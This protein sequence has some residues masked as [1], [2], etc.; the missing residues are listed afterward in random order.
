MKGRILARQVILDQ[1]GQIP[2]EILV[3][4][5]LPEGEIEPRLIE[6]SAG[7]VTSLLQT[8]TPSNLDEVERQLREQ[9]VDEAAMQRVIFP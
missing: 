5:L 6:P 7:A 2:V 9:G 3:R 8:Y 1:L 4:D